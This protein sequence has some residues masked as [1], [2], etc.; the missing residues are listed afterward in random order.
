M[1]PDTLMPKP[2]RDSTKQDDHK[3]ISLMN[4]DAIKDLQVHSVK[5]T[6][7][8]LINKKETKIWGIF[9]LQFGTSASDNISPSPYPRSRVGIQVGAWHL[10]V[11]S[12]GKQS[13]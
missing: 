2:H 6:R 8:Y 9:L 5:G 12:F 13:Q 3:P 7:E 1:S 11:E 10:F 4:T